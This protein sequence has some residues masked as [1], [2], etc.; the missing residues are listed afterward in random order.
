[1]INTIIHDLHY[2][3]FFTVLV[4]LAYCLFF[5][6]YSF[7]PIPLWEGSQLYLFF[8]FNPIIT[9]T[10]T[11]V[12]TVA[13]LGLSF[14]FYARFIQLNPAAKGAFAKEKDLSEKELLTHFKSIKNSHILANNTIAFAFIILIYSVLIQASISQD[15]LVYYASFLLYLVTII[16]I[17]GP[18]LIVWW[19]KDAIPSS[20][21]KKH[22]K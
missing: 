21:K 14:I 11:D 1:M 13:V 20:K 10:I 22:T 7:S 18:T 5:L 8:E 2:R 17:L 4:V 12:L 19:D 3:R 6:G 16:L 9:T 15:T